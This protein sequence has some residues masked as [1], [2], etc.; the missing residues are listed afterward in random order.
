MG[1]MILV[2]SAAKNILHKKRRLFNDSAQ[3]TKPAIEL[4]DTLPGAGAGPF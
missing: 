3:N 4:V 1:K 2:E